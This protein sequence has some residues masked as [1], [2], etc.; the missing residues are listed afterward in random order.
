MGPESREPHIGSFLL[1]HASPLQDGTLFLPQRIVEEHPPSTHLQ[2]SSDGLSERLKE[3]QAEE[4]S[5]RGRLLPDGVYFITTYFEHTPPFGNPY[6]KEDYTEKWA[7]SLHEALRRGASVRVSITGNI[8]PAKKPTTIRELRLYNSGRTIV[9]PQP[10]RPL[11]HFPHWYSSPRGFVVFPSFRTEGDI[12][13]LGRAQRV[14]E[15]D[16]EGKPVTEL[17]IY[18]MDMQKLREIGRVYHSVVEYNHSH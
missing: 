10:E 12:I 7:Q 18:V 3:L 9:E 15:K 17:A 1:S 8:S 14:L 6:N 11:P 2:R 5:R 4:F 16:R 13:V